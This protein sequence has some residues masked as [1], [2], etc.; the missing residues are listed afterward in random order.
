[1]LDD[2]IEFAI[3]TRADAEVLLVE[4]KAVYEAVRELSP[5]LRDTIIAVDIVGLTYKQAA[6]ALKTR[7]GTIMSRDSTRPANKSPKNGSPWMIVGEVT[8][9]TGRVAVSV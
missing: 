3:N 2:S 4:I 1:L 5:A 7:E 9:R 6:H 8:L